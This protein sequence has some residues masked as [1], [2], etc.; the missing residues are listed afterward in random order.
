MLSSSSSPDTIANYIS[1]LGGTAACVVAGRLAEADP[2][3]SILLIEGGQD[4]RGVQNIEN[5]VF[6]LDH[7]LP[8]STTT[9]FY[10]GNKSDNLGG[11]ESIV[12]CGGTLGGG[13]SINFMMYTRA[14]RS[15]F[16]SWKTPGWS[17]DEI[18]PFLKK[19]FL[20]ILIICGTLD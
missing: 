14:Q 17:A 11:R 3:L 9:L 12:P 19:V 1:L 16:D 6:F 5:P 13:S 18:Y 10:K 15:D 2:S 7:L 4:N 8:T 20:G